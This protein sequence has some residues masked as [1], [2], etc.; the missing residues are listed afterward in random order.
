MIRQDHI[1]EEQLE[2]DEGSMRIIEY[3]LALV[4]LATAVILA[5]IR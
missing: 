1:H 5:F 3:G 2:P 4:A